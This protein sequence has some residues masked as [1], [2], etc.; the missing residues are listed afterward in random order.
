MRI[1]SVISQTVC[2]LVFIFKTQDGSLSL[3][4]HSLQVSGR[5]SSAL[6][7]SSHSSSRP[8]PLL[9]YQRCLLWQTGARGSWSPFW[10]Q[11]R[12][13][14]RPSRWNTV[15]WAAGRPGGSSTRTWWGPGA[16][17][18]ASRATSHRAR[19]WYAWPA[20][21]GHP[22]TPAEVRALSHTQCDCLI[23]TKSSIRISVFHPYLSHGTFLH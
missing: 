23:P 15:M 5:N 18:A 9:N 4:S 10:M 2:G 19:R 17:S 14:A 13:G 21:T 1:L 20:S 16:R 7:S 11:A 6:T 12:R 3:S 22:T 8:N